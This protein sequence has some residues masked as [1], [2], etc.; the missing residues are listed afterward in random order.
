MDGPKVEARQGFSMVITIN[1]RSLL[2]LGFTQP[3]E[4][5]GFF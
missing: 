4:P 2:M 3:T 5:A 1:N